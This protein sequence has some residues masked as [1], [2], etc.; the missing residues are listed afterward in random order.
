MN[1]HTAANW[2]PLAIVLGWGPGVGA[3][4]VQGVRCKITEPIAVRS[5]VK[6]HLTEG[7]TVVFEAGITVADG[8]VK[9]DGQRYDLT[10]A[11]SVPVSSIALDEV[12]AMERYQTPV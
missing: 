12:A 1:R 10:L 2:V 4:P 6:V 3:E 7:S 11:T 8:Q 5:P 9:G